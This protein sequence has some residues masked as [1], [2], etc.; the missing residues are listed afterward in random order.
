M[1]GGGCGKI[2]SAQ[3]GPARAVSTHARHLQDGGRRAVTPTA[4]SGHGVQQRAV[5]GF[6][7][8]GRGVDVLARH[9]VGGLALP[10][11]LRELQS[12]GR[13]QR[14]RRVQPRR[15][16]EG[17]QGR[18]TPAD[19]NPQRSGPLAPER[20]GERRIDGPTRRAI[21][22]RARPDTSGP[23]PA[24]VSGS[25]SASS[26]PTGVVS[27]EPFELRLEDPERPDRSVRAGQVGTRRLDGER[28][29]SR[30]VLRPMSETIEGR[31]DHLGIAPARPEQEQRQ[32]RA[33]MI[34]FDLQGFVKSARG[35][36]GEIQRSRQQPSA[37]H[38]QIG[39]LG[40]G[41]TLVPAGSGRKGIR[42]RQLV[43]ALRPHEVASQ[44]P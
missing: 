42:F 15:L 16:V 27:S 28:R 18:L 20:H 13:H 4:S 17:G 14:V 38:Q 7:V 33:R 32:E 43:E 19:L 6:V 21:C 9:R 37:L 34:R 22:S 12:L 25:S 31:A 36:G 1:A 30:A 40:R 2:E 41:A 24:R 35:F 11:Q 3:I 10:E 23:A 29:T 39:A 8:G 44:G 26:I 5:D